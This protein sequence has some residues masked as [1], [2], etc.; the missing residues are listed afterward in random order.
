MCIRWKYTWRRA[1]QRKDE[2][3]F[4]NTARNEKKVPTSHQEKNKHVS[5]ECPFKIICIYFCFRSVPTGMPTLAWMLVELCTR[6]CQWRRYLGCIL[7]PRTEPLFSMLK[8]TLLP[9]HVTWCLLSKFPQTFSTRN[10]GFLITQDNSACV[11][12]PVIHLCFLSGYHYIAGQFTVE[13][14]WPN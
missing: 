2:F 6:E 14:I 4:L 3:Y 8:Y 11:S 13:T 10:T 12:C 9:P 1:E 5:A 7:A